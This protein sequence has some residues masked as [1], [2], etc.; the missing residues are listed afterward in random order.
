MSE[1]DDPVGPAEFDPR[2]LRNAFGMFA[3]GVSVVTTCNGDGRPIGLTCNSF[4]S[5]SLKPPLILWSLSLYSP[6]L[7]I[8]LQ[9][10]CFAINILACNQLDVSRRFSAPIRDRFDGVPWVAGEQG[11]PLI[12]GAA[13]HIQCRNES[14]HYSGDHVILIGQVVRYEYWDV[15]PLVFSRG[16]YRSLEECTPEDRPE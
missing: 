3:T 10:P 6:R 9:A 4:S 14:R 7:P 5:V 13:A 2:D 8:F 1:T 11:I 15:E 12:P 16:R